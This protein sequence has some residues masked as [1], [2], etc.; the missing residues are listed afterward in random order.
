MFDPLKVVV[1]L[2]ARSLSQNEARWKDLLCAR[3]RGG[4]HPADLHVALHVT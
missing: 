2:R 1:H 4:I 3:L